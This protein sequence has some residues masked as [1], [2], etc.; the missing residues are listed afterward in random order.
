M[1]R[2]LFL[3]FILAA[4]GA[5]P[6]EDPAPEES[7]VS[8]QLSINA[9]LERHAERLIAIEGIQGIAVGATDEGD[10]C[11]LILATVPAEELS[12]VLGDS[13]EGWP[14]RI[15]SGDEIRPLD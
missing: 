5:G 12:G 15:E 8:E 2:I 10:P 9:T 6:A 14:L 7:S 13:L 4:C 1:R 11:L 3:S